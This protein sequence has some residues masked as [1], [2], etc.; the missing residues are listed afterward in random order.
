MAAKRAPSAPSTP[1]KKFKTGTSA[2]PSSPSKAT[3]GGQ[4]KLAAFLAKTCQQN[5][6]THHDPQPAAGSN[7]AESD[8][9]MARRLQAEWD[10]ADTPGLPLNAQVDSV[11]ELHGSAKAE[12]RTASDSTATHSD[13]AASACAIEAKLPIELKARPLPVSTKFD[14]DRMLEHINSIPLEEDVLSFST[15]VDVSSWPVTE[16]KVGTGSTSQQ[17]AGLPE[18]LMPCSPGRASC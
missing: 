18:L 1:S 5:S 4:P 3:S 12:E 9:A 11:T 16:A 6:A 8:E 14:I 2:A 10:A 7:E 17:P 15:D 13:T